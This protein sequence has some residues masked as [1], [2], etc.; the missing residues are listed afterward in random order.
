MTDPVVSIITPSFNRADLLPRAWLSMRDDPVPFEWIIVDDASSDS[1]DAV[2][3]SFDDPRIV[4]LRL[5]QNQGSNIARN[6][7]LRVSRGRLVVLLDSDDELA[8]NSLIEAVR[9]LDIASPDIGAVLMIAQP[10]FTQNHKSSL[11]DGAV[12]DEEDLVI[13]NCLSGDRAVIY[14]REVFDKQMLPEAYRES[15]FVFVF[16]ISR[17]WNYLVV[18][19]PLT[20]VHR[21]NDNLSL[22]RSI[23]GRSRAIAQGWET[24]IQNHAVIL[25]QNASARF[26]LYMRMLYRYAVAGDWT[27]LWRAFKEVRTN[28]PGFLVAMKATGMAIAGVIG[29]YGGD[30]LRL[31]LIKIREE[32][33]RRRHLSSNDPG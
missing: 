15:Q 24:V 18:N 11:P 10:A 23:T 6:T 30:Y 5:N 20:V 17:W 16:G 19:K 2:V 28:H 21:Q 9:I 3:K 32:G 12:L 8:P 1:T 22:A 26:R 4:F 7:G 29:H 25:R 31:T 33:V 27:A 13:R 14:R